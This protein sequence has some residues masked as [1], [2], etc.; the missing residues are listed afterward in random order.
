MID[1]FHYWFWSSLNTWIYLEAHIYVIKKFI[2]N[3]VPFKK[4]EYQNQ[5]QKKKIQLI[6]H[7]VVYKNQN[8]NNNANTLY[9]VNNTYKYLYKYT[10]LH[11]Y[12]FIVMAKSKTKIKSNKISIIFKKIKFKNW[13]NKMIEC[14]WIIGRRTYIYIPIRR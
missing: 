2:I 12:T 1:L 13:S 5:D 4:I 6:N 14:N 11:I 10:H 8:N 7:Y 3:S 9:R